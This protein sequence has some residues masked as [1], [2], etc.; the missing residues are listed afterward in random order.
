M[1]TVRKKPDIR[2]NIYVYWH[3]ILPFVSPHDQNDRIKQAGFISRKQLTVNVCTP[4]ISVSNQWRSQAP[5]STFVQFLDAVT[6]LR[7]I[8]LVLFSVGYNLSCLKTYLQLHPA[9][10]ERFSQD[11]TDV[12]ESGSLRNS[13]YKTLLC[14]IQEWALDFVIVGVTA[15]CTLSFIFRSQ[16]ALK[17]NVRALLNELTLLFGRKSQLDFFCLLGEF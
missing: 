9:A 11:V 7:G 16:V 4:T 8:S 12:G 3:K 15:G 13:E 10:E 1:V 5:N 2:H 14:G 6:L 17:A